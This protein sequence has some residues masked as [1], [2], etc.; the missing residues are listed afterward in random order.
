V[1]GCHQLLGAL[2]ASDA[3]GHEALAIQAALQG[4]GLASEIYAGR[5]DGELR[6]RARPLEQRPQRGAWVYHFA[7]GSPATRAALGAAGPLALLYHNVTPASFLARWQLEA[8]RLSAEAA[9]ELRQLAPRVAL[10]LA[11][12]GFSRDDLVAAGFGR[13]ELL[14]FPDSAR[15]VAACPVLARLWADGRPTF[16]CVGRVAPNKRLEDV[17]RA[18][19]V[20]QSRHGRRSRLVVVGED[21]SFPRYAAALRRLQGALRLDEVVWTGRIPE[22]ELEAAYQAADALLL[23]SAHEGY[24]APLVEAMLRGVPVIARDAGGVRETLR[25]GGALLAAADPEAVADLMAG[26]A[27][28]GPLREAVLQTQQRALASRRDEDFAASL[29]RALGPLLDEAP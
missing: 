14:P 16:L 8:A 15:R 29:L 19:A 27:R 3:V 13:A 21:A 17:L 1:S 26:V 23:L 5:I 11:H 6:G 22:P 2:H 28:G 18:F 25:G 24:A 10:A 9:A 12:S 7:P 20:Y 4:A